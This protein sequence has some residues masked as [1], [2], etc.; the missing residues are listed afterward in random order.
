MLLCRQRGLQPPEIAYAV[1][2]SPR[3]VREYVALQDE[4]SQQ[5]AS[6]Q[7]MLHLPAP[8]A[9]AEPLKNPEVSFI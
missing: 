3:L 5:N 8:A 1:K 4:L 7:A 9:L 6:L 2:M